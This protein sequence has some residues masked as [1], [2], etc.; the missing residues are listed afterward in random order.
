MLVLTDNFSL[1]SFS[2]NNIGWL[3]V[4]AIML[5]VTGR[6][7]EVTGRKLEVTVEKLVVTEK[8]VKGLCLLIQK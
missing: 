2:S 4:T 6:K 8:E 1:F 3:F 7:L 5:V